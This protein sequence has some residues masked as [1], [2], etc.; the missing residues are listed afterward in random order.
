MMGDIIKS[1]LIGSTL[2]F[3][4]A[5]A[6]IISAQAHAFADIT[7]FNPAMLNSDM[8]ATFMLTMESVMIFG[9]W[10]AVYRL[11]RP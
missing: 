4:A 8:C 2:A 7:S 9:A 6:N 10:Y 3:S 5:L 1:S 11:V